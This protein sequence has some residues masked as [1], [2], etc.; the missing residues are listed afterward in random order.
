MLAYSFRCI[1]DTIV[2]RQASKSLMHVVVHENDNVPL[3][4][5]MSLTPTIALHALDLRQA[6]DAVHTEATGH[7][8]V[9]HTCRA[10]AT[11]ETFLH[12]LLYEPAVGSAATDG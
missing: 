7:V 5:A 4:P 8:W 11:S 10:Q 6:I 9:V 12:M 3:I 2:D 1:L